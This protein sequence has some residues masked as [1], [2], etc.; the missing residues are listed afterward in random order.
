MALRVLLADESL[1]IKKNIQIALQDYGVEIK[2][3]LSGDEVATATK[4]FKPDIIFL[5]VLLAKINGYD[6]CAQVKNHPD[7]RH[8]PVVLIW[9]SFM[10]LDEMK[11]RQSR[12]DGRLEKPFDKQ[13]LRKLIQHFVPKSKS[14]GLSEFLTLPELRNQESEAEDGVYSKTLT[15]F[16][17]RGGSL[18]DL[19]IE[20][21]PDEFQHGPSPFQSTIPEISPLRTQNDDEEEWVPHSL[22]TPPPMMEENY[23][24]EIAQV[25]LPPDSPM[26]TSPELDTL[27][28]MGRPRR[29]PPAPPKYS[30][31]PPQIQLDH[32]QLE[33]LVRAELRPVLEQAIAKALPEIAE[34]VIRE[35]IARLMIETENEL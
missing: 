14:Q 32:K 25:K 18:S 15:H 33:D 17:P 1:N 34:R 23:E 20:D 24:V 30:G 9:S 31:P 5:D 22:N 11:F 28:L 29:T 19:K 26:V 27:P 4:I 3:V 10:D 7:L 8:I 6:A 13:S 21:E 12:A 2:S 35:E 16:V